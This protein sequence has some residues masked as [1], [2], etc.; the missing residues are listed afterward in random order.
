MTKDIASRARIFDETSG[1]FERLVL[2][3][4]RNAWR[5][6]GSI[7]RHG[8]GITCLG[9]SRRA[10]GVLDARGS[11]VPRVFSTRHVR[12]L[13]C[14][15]G[16]FSSETP[17]AGRGKSKKA[18]TFLIDRETP[19][20]VKVIVLPKPVAGTAKITVSVF[21][22]FQGEKAGAGLVYGYQPDGGFYAFVVT[23][24]QGY[25]LYRGGSAE[26]RQISKGT[27]SAIQ[28]ASVNRLSAEL[29]GTRGRP[30]RQRRAGLRA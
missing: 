11:R 14:S 16:N 22:Q 19:G 4:R 25:A 1:L 18:R 30:V 23:P 7:V 13:K 15:R 3:R 26:L 8:M 28:V 9:F 5:E 2:R 24:N 12:P 6:G 10:D 17:T 29:D 27:N 20:A 21:G